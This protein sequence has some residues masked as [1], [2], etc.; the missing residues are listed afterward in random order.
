MNYHRYTP[1][2]I[3]SAGIDDTRETFADLYLELDRIRAA[4]DWQWHRAN[5]DESVELLDG[6]ERLPIHPAPAEFG[7]GELATVRAPFALGRLTNAGLTLYTVGVRI[8]LE[9]RTQLEQKIT[10]ARAELEALRSVP[11]RQERQRMAAAEQHAWD[12]AQHRKK[13]E[14]ELAKR[15]QS[16]VQAWGDVPVRIPGTSHVAA[17]RGPQP[18]EMDTRADRAEEAAT[19]NQLRYLSRLVAQQPGPYRAANGAIDLA[20]LRALSRAAASKLIRTLAA[21]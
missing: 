8:A 1:A 15:Q 18:R 5:V 21:A 16:T 17:P 4:A 13:L 20:A 2:E 14:A 6:E 9:E 10:T 7:G 12:A 11:A 19:P 3:I